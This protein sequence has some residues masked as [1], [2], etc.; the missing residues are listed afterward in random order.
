MLQKY[1]I[2]VI[3]F[4]Q[5]LILTNSEAYTYT[6]QSVNPKT[7]LDEARAITKLLFS[8][9]Y[10]LNPSKLI[11]KK[12]EIFSFQ[13]DLITVIER[14]QQDEP[15]QYII[16]HTYFNGLKISVNKNVLIPRPETEELVYL[17]KELGLENAR[18][19]ADICTGS[20]CIALS[21]LSFPGN[22]KIIATDIS[23]TA[24]ATAIANEKSNFSHSVIQFEHHDI[25]TR[26]WPYELPDMV[27]CNPPYI[28]RKEAGIM[29]KNVLQYEPHLALF[30]EHNDPLLF[31]KAVIMT[32]LPHKFPKV[33]FE[34]NPLNSLALK[35][36][37]T[38]NLL[39]CEIIKDMQ[40]KL[41]FAVISKSTK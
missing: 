24:L 22:N 10:D 21:A 9:K 17:A 12:D 1:S 25:L 23:K 16:G 14:L 18:I 15:I 32:F 31:Y 39:E 8:E 4:A 41:R 7:N 40:G 6:I 29:S 34:I 26:E 5:T 35:G 19:I 36:F 28:E 38:I 2:F 3:P 30:V 33:F 27:I 20:G 13:A 37:C 11:S